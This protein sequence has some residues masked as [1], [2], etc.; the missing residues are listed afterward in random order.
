MVAFIL[1]EGEIYAMPRPSHI[2]L[3]LLHS[4][5]AIYHATVRITILIRLFVR[6]GANLIK[7]V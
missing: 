3:S 2:S 5:L 6:C 1:W 4:P 7:E